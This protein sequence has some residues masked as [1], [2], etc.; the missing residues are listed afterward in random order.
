MFCT[1][2]GFQIK[3][4]YKFC[5]KCGA[6]AYVE[7]VQSEVKEEV[8]QASKVVKDEEVINVKTTA[9]NEKTNNEKTTS[10]QNIGDTVSNSQGVFYILWFVMLLA[11]IV[12]LMGRGFLYKIYAFLLAFGYLFYFIAHFCQR[13][14]AVKTAGYILFVAACFIFLTGLLQLINAILRRPACSCV[15]PYP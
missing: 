2:C 12:A 6:P 11:L 1:K 9:T 3:D 7:K 13:E 10:S 15:H 5:P 4:G 14:W 8:N